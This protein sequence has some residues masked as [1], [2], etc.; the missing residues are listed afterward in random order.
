MPPAGPEE[1]AFPQ[2]LP[3]L[4]EIGLACL[5]SHGHDDAIR[6]LDPEGGAPLSSVPDNV[7]HHGDCRRQDII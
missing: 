4:S 6:A 7:E 3:H 2:D 1:I 5:P